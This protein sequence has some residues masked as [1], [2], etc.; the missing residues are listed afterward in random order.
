MKNIPIL[1]H[2]KKWLLLL[3]FISTFSFSQENAVTYELFNNDELFSE[4]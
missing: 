4:K 3:L 1:L 2:S